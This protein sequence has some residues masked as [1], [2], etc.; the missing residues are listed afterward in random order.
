MDVILTTAIGYKSAVLVPFMHSLRKVYNGR[1][2][3]VISHTQQE[4]MSQLI[5]SYNVEP[6]LVTPHNIVPVLAE[7]FLIYRDFLVLNPEIKRCFLTDSRD[8][9]FQSSPFSND[10]PHLYLYSEPVIFSRCNINSNWMRKCYDADTLSAYAEKNVVC[11]GTTVGTYT[12]I[13]KYINLMCNEV[14][15]RIKDRIEISWGE[16]Q[17]MHNYLYYSGQLP[18]AQVRA[19]GHSEVQTLHHEKYFLFDKDCYLLNRDGA[20]VPVIHQYDRHPQFFAVFY[21]MLNS[22]AGN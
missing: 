19:H 12:L 9:I 20:R 4:E 21:K 10:L 15:K 8:V 5:K 7:R 11:S 22:V 18:E 1:L 16:D 6:L 2:V 13:L 14:E 3:L 17:A